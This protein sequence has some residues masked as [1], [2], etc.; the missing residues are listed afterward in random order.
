MLAQAVLGPCWQGLRAQAR[1]RVG[2]LPGLAA[3]L[4][5][6]RSWPPPPSPISS[7]YPVQ[8]PPG[9]DGVCGLLTPRLHL[10]SLCPPCFPAC[11]NR[12]LTVFVG[13]VAWFKPK[14]L[15]MENVQARCGH[16][17]HA[18]VAL[19]SCY[20][21]SGRAVLRGSSVPGLPGAALGGAFCRAPLAL[22]PP[23]RS[24]SSLASPHTFAFLHAPTP[25]DMVKVENGAY[26]K[27]AVGSMLDQ[28]YQ[29][30]T[31]GH[32]SRPLAPACLPRLL[33]CP[34]SCPTARP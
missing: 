34:P 32:M 15:L 20:A 2:V 11:S 13:Y 6:V 22:A 29:A 30:R 12:Q 31:S 19:W 16:A 23:H 25:Q 33:L 27:Y 1:W 14:Y 3:P 8:Q 21:C 17:A 26:I 24:P 7:P 10:P 4:A 5:H 9:A 28:R 18:V